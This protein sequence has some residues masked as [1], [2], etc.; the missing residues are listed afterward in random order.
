MMCIRFFKEEILD[1]SLYNDRIAAAG[2]AV[3]VRPGRPELLSYTVPVRL[4]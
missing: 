1:L 4:V 3:M 2:Q